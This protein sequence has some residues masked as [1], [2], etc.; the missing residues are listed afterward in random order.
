MNNAL[1]NDDDIR[2][3]KKEN[4]QEVYIFDPYNSLNKE[5]TQIEVE[6]IIARYGISLP[7]SNF[8]LY[9]RSFVHRSYTKR[10][11]LEN[12]QNNIEIVPKPD[13]CIALYTKSNERLEFIGIG[14]INSI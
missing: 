5:I 7:I 10:P 6:N 1:L 13:D 3:E 11:T 12:I 4:G 8:N 9:R 14:D 2:I